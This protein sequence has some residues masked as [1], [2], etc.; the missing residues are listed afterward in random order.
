ML[1]AHI[2]QRFKS[3]QAKGLGA[4]DRF[5]Y[6]DEEEYL[7]T[8][9]LAM[10]L[11]VSLVEA[12]SRLN[13]RSGYHLVFLKE[14]ESLIGSF[15]Q[16]PTFRRPLRILDVGAGGGGLLRA[17]YRWAERKEM[18]VE[19]VGVDLSQ[20]FIQ[21]TRS[22]LHSQ[23][24]PIRLIQGDGSSL[25]TIQDASFDVVISSY[26]AHHIRTAGKVA[27]FLSEVYRVAKQGWLVADLDRRF[28]A[29]IFVKLAGHLFGAP[30]LLVSDGVKSVRRAYNV[31]E[32]NLIIDEMKKLGK[33]SS[34]VC[35]P[36]PFFPYWLIKGIKGA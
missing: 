36:Y 7:E 34:M 28:Y 31:K 35:R 24:F 1:E 21:T 15:T 23:G 8:L 26:M 17:V 29:P 32:I 30:S 10:E 4:I 25:N 6:K 19:L 5:V 13:E 9:G 18:A 27:L 11:R 22:R 12:L 16:R 14:L 2:N 33:V 3:Y 20:D